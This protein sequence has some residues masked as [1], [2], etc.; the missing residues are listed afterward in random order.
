[1]SWIESHD[2]LPEHPKLEALS[3]S[4][5][6]DI[7]LTLGKL[8]RFWYWCVKYAENGDLRK[9]TDDQLGKPVGLTGESA[10]K[11]VKAMKKHEW[12]DKKPFFRVHDWWDYIGPWLRSKYKRS[13]LKWQ[14][15]RSAYRPG[16]LDVEVQPVRTGYVTANQP[17]QPTNPPINGKGK[18]RGDR[19]LETYA[20]LE[21]PS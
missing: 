19:F 15:V 1:M 3:G 10:S 12:F 11:F 18:S 4:M 17:N 20:P 5:G 16:E 14:A 2:S 8:H 21:P 6:W 7:D 9:F 13:P